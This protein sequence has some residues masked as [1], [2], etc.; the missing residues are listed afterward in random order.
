[1]PA[2]SQCDRGAGT[3][4]DWHTQAGVILDAEIS[5]FAALTQVSALPR[6]L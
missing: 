1:M 6:D 4:Y 2:Q 3:L 5:Q